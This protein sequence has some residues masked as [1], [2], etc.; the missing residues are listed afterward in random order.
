MLKKVFLT[1]LTACCLTSV[2][3]SPALS[4]PGGNKS[5]GGSSTPQGRDIGSG[6]NNTSGNSENNGCYSANNTPKKCN[7]TVK[8]PEP[9]AA[10]PVIALGALLVGTQAVR[11][12]K[13]ASTAI[14]K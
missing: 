3:I 4:A 12:M 9:S 1:V 14:E 5:P 7:D 11:K 6:Q 8:V 13:S 2:A 10:I